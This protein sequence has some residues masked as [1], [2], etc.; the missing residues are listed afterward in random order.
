MRTTATD[1]SPVLWVGTLG[2]LARL[3]DGRWSVIDERAGLIDLTIRSLAETEDAGGLRSIW[4]GT[5]AGVARLREGT[6]T[7]EGTEDGLPNLQIHCLKESRAGGRRRL[8][9]GTVGGGAAYRDLDLPPGQRA[10]WVTLSDSTSPALPNNTVY[11]IEEDAKGLLYLFTNKGVA[12][13][14][15]DGKGSFTVFTF[16]TEDG[17]PSN[18]CNTG[19][20]MVDSQ[21]RIWA[22]TI[23]GAAVFD[24]AAAFSDRSKK[25]LRIEAIR[26]A[27]RNV[28][29]S[30]GPF[31][32]AFDERPVS[33]DYVLLSY[34]HEADTRYRTRLVGLD[35]APGDWT[36]AH[37]KAYE[38]LPAG[39][40]TFQ[41]WAR[42]YAGNESGPL[43]LTLRVRPAPWR[44]PVA[45]G[46]YL[47]A[48]AG[49]VWGALR[50]RDR[51]H[52]KLAATLQAMVRE[53]TAELDLKTAELERANSVLERLA[54]HDGLTGVANRRTFDQALEAHWS[55]ARRTGE[56]VALLMVD[57]DRFKELNDRCGH[58]AGDECLR[59]VAQTLSK[60]LGRPADLVARYGGE[61]FVVLLPGT[62]PEGAALVAERLRLEVEAFGRGSWDGQGAAPTVSVGVVA[63][64]PPTGTPAEWLVS[65]A[66]QALYAAKRQ[67]RNRVVVANAGR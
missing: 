52:R 35:A 65:L 50:L 9:A 22:G 29:P 8:W 25:P 40:Y 32:L 66:D 15:P 7:M 53:R 62:S 30:S 37:E 4:M 54:A 14:T 47:V 42:D 2:G 46:A 26:V 12:R 45:Y 17:L 51:S 57:V 27:G 49:A 44:T 1:G 55:L 38:Y 16:T 18:E 24:P 28:T 5:D 10:R 58:Q 19:A 31:D 63:S 13:L 59:G 11:R 23:A 41:L 56:P 43:E 6:V 39:S 61:E 21:G 3:A 36:S 67:G 20:S 48:I 34:V 33:F 64:V 60:G